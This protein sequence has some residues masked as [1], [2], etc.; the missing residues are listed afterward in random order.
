M[1]VC[2]ETTRK[3]LKDNVILSSAVHLRETVRILSNSHRFKEK[4]RFFLK[5]SR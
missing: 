2:N 1:F 3:S 4:V 5:H